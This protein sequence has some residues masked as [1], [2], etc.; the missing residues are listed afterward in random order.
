MPNTADGYR[1][2]VEHSAAILRAAGYDLIPLAEPIGKAWDLL[3][4]APHGLILVNVVQGDLPEPF[5]LQRRHPAPVA[6]QHD[7]AGSQVHRPRPLA[8]GAPPVK[9]QPGR[10]LPSTPFQGQD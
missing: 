1:A 10:L 6:R 4:V 5:G 7:P 8:A 2:D 9:S 3:G